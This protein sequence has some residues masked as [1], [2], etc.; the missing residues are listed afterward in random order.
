MPVFTLG[1]TTARGD[2][3][4]KVLN[5]LSRLT[6]RFKNKGSYW[7]Y[8]DAILEAAP[9]YLINRNGLFIFTNDEDLANN[10]VNGYGTD[11]LSRIEAKK[12]R[13]SGFMYGNI[14]WANAIEKFPRSFFNERQNEIIDAM[15]GKT[16]RM[17]L[18]T[19]ETTKEKTNFDLIYYF[20]GNYDNSGKYLLDLLNSIYV[21]SK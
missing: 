20:E 16:G 18:T 1:F 15:R 12:S 8:E 19:S 3:P 9:L 11:A 21:I 6:S 14:D 13:K 4:E 2:I 7:V 17:E 10:H 5:H